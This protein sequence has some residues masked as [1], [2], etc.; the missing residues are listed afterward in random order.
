MKIHAR[1]R[2][3]RIVKSLKPGFPTSSDGG[4]SSSFELREIY[5]P[6]MDDY[7][8]PRVSGLR[9]RKNCDSGAVHLLCV[10]TE[11]S[12]CEFVVENKIGIDRLRFS[13]MRN[14]TRREGGGGEE[15]YIVQFDKKL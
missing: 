6:F 15:W 9:A 13:R 11:W 12:V 10:C 3:T 14:N 8:W 1:L 7:V 2:E 5:T 4:V